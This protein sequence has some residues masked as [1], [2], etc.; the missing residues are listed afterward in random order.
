MIVPKL[1]WQIVTGALRATGSTDPDVL[2]AKKEELLIESRRMKFLGPFAY[3]V[4]GSMCL[5]IIGAVIGIPI[6]LFGRAV[7]KTVKGNIAVADA[8]LAEF[9]QSGGVRRATA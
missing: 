7:S 1:D 9:L 5:T 6:V 3:I 8:A 4:G 2:Y